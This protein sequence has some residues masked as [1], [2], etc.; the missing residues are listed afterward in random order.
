MVEHA[1]AN[2]GGGNFLGN[3]IALRRTVIQVFYCLYHK[4]K[5]SVIFWTTCRATIQVEMSRV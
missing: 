3:W 2:G 5:Y 1:L 4:Y